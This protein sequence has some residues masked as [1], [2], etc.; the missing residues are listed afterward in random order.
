MFRAQINEV[1]QQ[2][3]ERNHSFSFFLLARAQDLFAERL[4][5]NVAIVK[6]T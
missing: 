3:D 2:P 4:D 1:I 6:I 5:P